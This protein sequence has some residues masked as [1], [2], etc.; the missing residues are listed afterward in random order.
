MIDYFT[1]YSAI[2]R[3]VDLVCKIKKNL[4]L[5]ESVSRDIDLRKLYKSCIIY[6]WEELRVSLFGFQCLSNHVR[7]TSKVNVTYLRLFRSFVT[8]PESMQINVNQ[9]LHESDMCDKSKTRYIH[10]FPYI[11]HKRTELFI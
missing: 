9:L 3:N 8:S 1:N 6:D 4:F 7:E 11:P 2:F 10:I 5:M